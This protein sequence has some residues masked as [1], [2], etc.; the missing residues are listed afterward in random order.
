MAE[1]V[2]SGDRVL[3]ERLYRRYRDRMVSFVMRWVK[4]RDV[5][6]ELAQEVFVR[7]YTTKRYAADA[8]F[9]AWLYRVA[10][11]VCLNEVR[12]REYKVTKTEYQDANARG[13]E[14]PA[15]ELDARELSRRLGAR[16]DGLPKKQRMAF[17]LCRH[18]GLSH[19]E[20]ADAL[21][22]SVPATKSLI[23][24]ALEALREEVRSHQEA[25]ECT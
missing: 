17:I 19:A 10:T 3:F 4:Q 21:G 20:I 24:R 18:E 16:L 8:P 9:K 14:G 12:R 5:A 23:H 25:P 11:N 22:T 1:F 2:R 7:V 15:D 13:P 6:E